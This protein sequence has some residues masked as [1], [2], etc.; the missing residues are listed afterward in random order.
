M[1]VLCSL[2][3]LEDPQ[4]SQRPQNADPERHAGSEEAPNYLKDAAD[5]HLHN[6][7]RNDKASDDGCNNSSLKKI[8]WIYHNNKKKTRKK[9]KKENC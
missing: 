5:N 4:K 3:D 1:Y 8:Q 9:D 6:T 2:G 7:W